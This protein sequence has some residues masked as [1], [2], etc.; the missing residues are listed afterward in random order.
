MAKTIKL[1]KFI[2]A[3]G[4]KMQPMAELSKRGQ[5][6]QKKSESLIFVPETKVEKDRLA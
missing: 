2:Q 3:S 4:T 6:L 1:S 5:K